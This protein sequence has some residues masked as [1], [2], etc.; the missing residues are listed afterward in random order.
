MHRWHLHIV[1]GSGSIT[2][3]EESTSI[4]F[5]IFSVKAQFFRQCARNEYAGE[6]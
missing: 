4:A 3:G 2:D 6:W 5:R 1:G